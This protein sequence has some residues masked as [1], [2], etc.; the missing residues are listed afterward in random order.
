M[1]A[2]QV[3]LGRGA[4]CLEL[5]DQ[6]QV[7]CLDGGHVGGA[8]HLG[9]AGVEQDSRGTSLAD[10]RFGKGGVHDARGDRHAA[11]VAPAGTAVF[12][13]MSAEEFVP[14]AALHL[15]VAEEED[16]VGPNGQH[17]GVGGTHAVRG[18]QTAGV[19]LRLG[20][21]R[22]NGAYG[23]FLTLGQIGTNGFA[24]DAVG[25]RREVQV[26]VA[27]HAAVGHAAQ[28]V[29]QVDVLQPVLGRFVDEGFHQ[30]VGPEP[31][32]GGA[33]AGLVLQDAVEVDFR[34]R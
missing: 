9:S 16:V 18:A 34:L 21:G 3:N 30:L 8:V 17:A 23:I 25:S 1:H 15:L 6:G 7:V 26:V 27:P 32:L 28:R 12:H 13:R 33:V 22:I 2:E 4:I 11:A 5:V 20:V 29:V 14:L 31:A 10:A 19:L 24:P